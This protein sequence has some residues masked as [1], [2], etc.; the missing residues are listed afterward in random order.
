MLLK[1]EAITKPYKLHLKPGF[2]IPSDK[3]LLFLGFDTE[4]NETEFWPESKLMY[5]FR[6]TLY[7]QWLTKYIT[8][9]R[10]IIISTNGIVYFWKAPI[11]GFKINDNKVDDVAYKVD[12]NLLKRMYKVELII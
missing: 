5:G 4:G 2:K 3:S 10:I 6:G 1:V 9:D 7:I 11:Y 8:R 12:M